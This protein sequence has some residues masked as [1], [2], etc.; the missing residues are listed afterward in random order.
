MDSLLV[1]WVDIIFVVF[2][3]SVTLLSGS[4]LHYLE[5]R[6]LVFGFLGILD[7]LVSKCSFVRSYALVMWEWYGTSKSCRNLSWWIECN[8]CTLHLA[9]W[10]SSSNALMLAKLKRS[11]MEWTTCSPSIK[12]H[13]TTFIDLIKSKR[14]VLDWRWAHF[15]RSSWNCICNWTCWISLNKKIDQI[16]KSVLKVISCEDSVKLMIHIF[17]LIWKVLNLSLYLIQSPLLSTNVIFCQFFSDEKKSIVTHDLWNS[18]WSDQ[19]SWYF[20]FLLISSLWSS[21]SYSLKS[22][23]DDC[24]QKIQ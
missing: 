12:F 16:I 24:N 9:Y 15:W 2:E 7:V 21:L 4:H 3:D 13:Y 5:T 14:L 11:N 17:N 23:W 18:K 19:L 8:T 10:D 20:S 1:F 22:S 6:N